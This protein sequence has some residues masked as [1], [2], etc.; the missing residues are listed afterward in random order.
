M[1]K[2]MVNHVFVFV[3]IH[4][5]IIWVTRTNRMYNFI[6]IEKISYFIMIYL[7]LEIGLLK[8]QN[9]LFRHDVVIVVIQKNVD[10]SNETLTNF[11]L[12]LM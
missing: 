9:N 7:N 2:N 8:Y 6:D 1:Y 10:Y 12:K 4:L 5:C 11:L 3:C